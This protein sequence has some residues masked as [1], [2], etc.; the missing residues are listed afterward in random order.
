MGS[1]AMIK[2]FG[3]PVA[4]KIQQNV[5]DRTK[6]FIQKYQRPPHLSVVLVGDDP[7]SVIYTRR[8][9]EAATS[10]GM[11]HQTLTLP[12]SSTPEHVKAVVDQLNQ[13]PKV[14]G[15][16]I[17]RPLPKGFREEEVLYWVSPEKD[18]DAFHPENAGRLY[19]GLS[20]FQPCTA[21]G[22]ME[23]LR[24]Y[25][26]DPRGKIACVVGRSS[27]VGKPMASLL[28]QADATVVHC[29]SKTPNLADV[30]RQA[31]I[32][33][34]AAGKLGLIGATHVKKGAVVIDVGM[35]RT[36]EGKV[37]GDVL[38]ESVAKVASAMSPVPGGVG[39]MTIA[40]LMENTIRAAELRE[41]KK[42]PSERK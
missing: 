27:I 19:L 28:L 14:D 24:N 31:D 5:K 10:L 1:D 40:V 11:T 33:I 6:K 12:H 21:A 4:E 26:I 13:D 8:K 30:T 2:L 3:K 9:G 20:A 17:Q 42:S 34:V 37:T 22:I 39:P 15:I 23:L 38:M 7:A 35:H 25:N 36:S 41:N 16:L 18:V 32:L 29:H